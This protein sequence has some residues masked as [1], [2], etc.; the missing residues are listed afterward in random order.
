MD[1]NVDWFCCDFWCVAHLYVTPLYSSPDGQTRRGLDGAQ[2]HPRHQHARPW[3]ARAGLHREYTLARPFPPHCCSA[4]GRW[5]ISVSP[6]RWTG[7]KSPSSWTSW[8]RC[9]MSQPTLC[10][11]SS[12]R[13]RLSSEEYVCVVF[14]PPLPPPRPGFITVWIHAEGKLSAF[15][16]R[17][18]WHSWN[19]SATQWKTTL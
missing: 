2:A 3:R 6:C 4:V 16:N 14:L 15:L 11:R 7:L 5:Q 19:A 9:R 17:S 1:R 8:W 18:G 13:S 12:S 10:S